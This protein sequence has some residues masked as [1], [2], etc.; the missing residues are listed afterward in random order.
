M[1]TPFETFV[2]TELPK[3]IATNDAPTSPVAGEIPV[4]TGVG[5]MT[6][7]KTASEAGLASSGDLS[8]HISNTGNPHSVTKAQVGLG[9]VDNTSD[10]N[11]PVS[12]AT[13]AAL[14]TKQTID[15]TLTALAGLDASAGLVVQTGADT[16]AKRTLT[17]TASQIDVTNGTGASGHPTVALA[18]SGVTAGSYGSASQIPVLT[19]DAKGRLT[20]ASTVAITPPAT[21][22]D[23]TFRIQD[24]TDAT[25]QKAFE[26][27]GVATGTTRTQ[28]VADKNWNEGDLPTVATTNSNVLSGTNTAI[29]GGSTN[30]V[31]GSNVTAIATYALQN[32][33]TWPCLA[34]GSL[35]LN[36]P[37][38]QGA[39][40]IELNTKVTGYSDQL[41]G[42]HNISCTTDSG[43]PSSTTSPKAVLAL[44]AFPGYVFA[45]H[46]IEFMCMHAGY[47]L[48]LMQSHF[49]YAVRRVVVATLGGT[50]L[51]ASSVQ[52]VGTDIVHGIPQGTTTFSIDVDVANNR[53]VPKVTVSGGNQ[54][55]GVIAKVT[56]L[57]ST[58]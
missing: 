26:V 7:F 16:F 9:N 27:S 32:S 24:N 6:E 20:A 14:D 38:T 23:S 52:T 17:G 35:F 19:V 43:V 42:N 44:P 10:A 21:F 18:N 45:V 53:I 3:R 1:A 8:A 49:I 56:S 47:V 39:S 48:S 2:N 55:C 36:A 40:G 4:A 28:T 12:I 33:V 11:K 13:Q 41:S 31:S 29:L 57:H 51:S 34:L 54:Y 5:L 46:T 50:S 15:P 30:T 25:K 22:S 58:R 37:T